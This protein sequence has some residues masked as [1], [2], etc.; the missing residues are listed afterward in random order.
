MW[1]SCDSSDSVNCEREL[2][3]TKEQTAC[4]DLP[5]EWTDKWLVAVLVCGASFSCEADT[6]YGLAND[7]CPE[8]SSECTSWCRGSWFGSWLSVFL[9]EGLP[10]HQS[11]WSWTCE[12][13]WKRSSARWLIW[14][15]SLLSRQSS[16]Q[17]LYELWVWLEVIGNVEMK[18]W[19]LAH[20]MSI[21]RGLLASPWTLRLGGWVQVI[22]NS[23]HCA[24][25]C[26]YGKLFG[27]SCLGDRCNPIS[28]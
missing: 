18:V 16:R 2:K 7:R 27:D 24:A 11:S 12:S 6:S 5:S 1:S 3:E 13:S 20:L 8:V 19:L 15:S 25:M 17:H 28:I 10:Y 21:L 23:W 26:V 22:W 9:S 4:Y 14:E